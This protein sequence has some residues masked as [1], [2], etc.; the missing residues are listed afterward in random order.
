MADVSSGSE[1][2]AAATSPGASRFP[3]ASPAIS[4]NREKREDGTLPHRETRSQEGP[5]L[6]LPEG[7]QY[8]TQ[9]QRPMEG[10][11]S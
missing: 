8:T 1:E 10:V 2:N 9:V 6:D 5:H 3:G 4:E 11:L 7:G